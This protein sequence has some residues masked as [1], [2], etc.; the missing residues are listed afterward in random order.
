VIGNK[1][2]SESFKLVSCISNHSSSPPELVDFF[3]FCFIFMYPSLNYLAVNLRLAETIGL[4]F[5]AKQSLGLGKK[6]E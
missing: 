3:L 4:I 1:I 2:P 6:S 5:A